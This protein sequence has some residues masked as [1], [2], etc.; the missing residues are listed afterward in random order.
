MYPTPPHSEPSNGLASCGTT[1]GL[2]PFDHS[3]I[4]SDLLPF[5]PSHT[6][7]SRWSSQSDRVQGGTAAL[8]SNSTH[9][10]YQGLGQPFRSMNHDLALRIP[11]NQVASTSDLTSNVVYTQPTCD[12]LPDCFNMNLDW[13]VPTSG[14]Q[15]YRH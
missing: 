14:A 10:G 9:A 6:A 2:S 13:A 8:D 7:E 12:P 3:D 4:H 11:S 15:L 1:F 5:I